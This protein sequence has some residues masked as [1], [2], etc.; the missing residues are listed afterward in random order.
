MPPLSPNPTLHFLAPISIGSANIGG[1]TA[2]DNGIDNEIRDEPASGEL[3]ARIQALV[4]QGFRPTFTTREIA[5][6][7]AATGTISCSL[8][9]SPLKTFAQAGDDD[10]RRAATGH[11]QFH[12]QHG[13]LVP[14]SLDCS[15]QGDC[16]ISYQAIVTWDGTHDPLVISTSASLP[17]ISAASLW[18]LKSATLGGVSIPQ[19]QN[20]Q[21]QFGVRAQGE[22]AD[23]DI[24][25]TIASIAAVQPVVT[26][27][28]SKIAALLPVIGATGTVSVTFRERADGGTFSGRELTLSGSG[29]AVFSKPFGANGGRHGDNSI[30]ARLKYDGTHDPLVVTTSW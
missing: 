9:A 14:Q 10:G 11:V 5:A 13:I 25:A 26:V 30:E 19:L 21:I 16:S 2:V 7:L 22:G 24:W 3:T 4:A 18:T 29:M 12:Y 17:A 6:A 8:A 23:S 1:I 15:H 28:A 20:V 27:T